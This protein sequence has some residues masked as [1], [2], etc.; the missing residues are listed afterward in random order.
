MSKTF[1]S[2]PYKK[3][4]QEGKKRKKECRNNK[5]AEIKTLVKNT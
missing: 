4:R 2:K 1:R 3:K 5:K